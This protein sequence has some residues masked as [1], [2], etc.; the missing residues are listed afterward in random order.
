MT[1]WSHHHAMRQKALDHNLVLSPAQHIQKGHCYR[2]HT[3]GLVD[4]YRRMIMIHN[5]K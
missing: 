2:A 3:S 5:S 4:N 1:S